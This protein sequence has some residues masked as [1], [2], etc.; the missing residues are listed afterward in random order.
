MLYSIDRT[1]PAPDFV[2]ENPGA[3]FYVEAVTVNPTRD[4]TVAI[5]PEPEINS[6]EDFKRYRLHY[7][8]IKFGSPLTSKLARRY[9]DLPHVAET[10]LLFAIQDFSARRSM[11]RSRL[12]FETYIYGYVH[13]WERDSD[14]KLKIIP[15]KIESPLMGDQG[16]SLGFF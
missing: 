14:G 11:S 7:M 1:H 5:V 9:W 15:R 12:V 8:P 13:D 2:C 10:P 3:R 6:E 16:N 4:K